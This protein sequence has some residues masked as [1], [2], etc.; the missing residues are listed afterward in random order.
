MVLSPI[1]RRQLAN[2]TYGQAIS[3]LL[4][5]T[6]I[7]TNKLQG[8]NALV[9]TFSTTFLY[10]MLA[11]VFIPYFYLM[12]RP[13]VNL[14]IWFWFLFGLIDVEANYWAVAA[15]AE[16]VNY[17]VLGLILHMTIP[18][19]TVL[20]YF[21][22][23]KR[24]KVIHLVGCV[25][26]IA[27]ICVVFGASTGNYAD[28]EFP[29]QMRGNLKS[30]LASAFYAL[31]N[32]MMEFAVKRNDNGVDANIEVLGKMGFFGVLVSCI[33]MAIIGE[34]GRVQDVEW[35]AANVGWNV[36]YVLT[37][38]A[39]YVTVSIFLRVTEALLFNISLLTSDLY[40][41]LTMKWVFQGSVPDLY[42]LAWGLECI[43][44]TVYSIYEP[45]DLLKPQA[46]T[47]DVNSIAVETPV[48]DFTK[49]AYQKA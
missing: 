29:N 18:I 9:V 39:F 23:G 3:I 45:T 36:G 11:A 15:F 4:V 2:F 33:Q 12:K 40:S 20:S 46:P 49:D 35:T 21:F 7:F 32:L 6:S 14:P 24:Y 5:C 22:M 13:S 17:A 34:Y 38:F 44:I 41:A 37:M 27:G 31:S 30:L 43:G 26:A 1:V 19:V 47:D 10:V 25:F 42:W 16:N 28:Q 8:N 48:D